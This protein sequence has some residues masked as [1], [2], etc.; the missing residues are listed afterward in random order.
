[1]DQASLCCVPD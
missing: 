1:L